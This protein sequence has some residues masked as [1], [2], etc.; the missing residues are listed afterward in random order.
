MAVLQIG[1]C[2]IVSE[3]GYCMMV[4]DLV[5]CTMVELRHCMLVGEL[6]QDLD[7]DINMV[8]EL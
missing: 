5:R 2:T 1:R 7:Q 8:E 3:L 6:V 4:E